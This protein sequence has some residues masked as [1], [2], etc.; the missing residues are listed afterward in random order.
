MSYMCYEDIFFI[1]N[2]ALWS[3][4]E[5]FVLLKPVPYVEYNKTFPA[6]KHFTIYNFK[7]Y[8]KQNLFCYYMYI[9]IIHIICI[10]WLLLLAC[11][12][13]GPQKGRR[14]VRY[15]HDYPFSLRS[16]T[17]E[18]AVA[19]LRVK[20]TATR[21]QQPIICMIHISPAKTL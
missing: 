17:T 1:D 18:D 19:L 8:W 6:I 3:D 16:R 21:R 4:D 15:H 9:W 11:C 5:S 12:C 20:T 7:E 2:K 14:D 10:V 13:F